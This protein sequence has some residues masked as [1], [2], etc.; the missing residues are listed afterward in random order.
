MDKPIRVMGQLYRRKSQNDLFQGHKNI[1]EK[2][3]NHRLALSTTNRNK[4]GSKT[5]HTNMGFVY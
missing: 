4:P 2:T 3:T 5:L 1:K